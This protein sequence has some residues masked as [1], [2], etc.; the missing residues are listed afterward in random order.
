[1]PKYRS[2]NQYAI[3]IASIIIIFFCLILYVT[4]KNDCRELTHENFSLEQEVDGYGSQIKY[5][6]S[7]INILI[8]RKRIERIAMEKFNLIAADPE[9]IIVV[10]K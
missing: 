6:A 4:I 1:M 5:N 10:L 3:F 2:N 7:D 9:S 8:G